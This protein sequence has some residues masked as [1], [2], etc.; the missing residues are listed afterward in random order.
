MAPGLKSVRRRRY[1]ALSCIGWA[2]LERLMARHYQR[3]GYAVEHVGTGGT[4]QRFDGGIDLKLRKGSAYVLVQCK[5]WNAKQVPHNAVHELLGLMVNERATGAVLVTSGEFTRAAIEAA[6]KQDRVQLVDGDA[7]RTLLGPLLDDEP[8]DAVPEA[9]TPLGRRPS[10]MATANDTWAL[11]LLLLF[12][13]I[14]FAL[15]LLWAMSSAFRQAL[16]PIL[17]PRPPVSG[18]APVVRPEPSPIA[19]APTTA[20]PPVDA[21]VEA[22]VAMP[23]P[24]PDEIRA[25]RRKADEA[26]RVIEATTPA[27]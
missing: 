23:A 13:K 17:V 1:D 9:R 19:S 5:H 22:P 7:L 15:A 4:R 3:E 8:A 24:T 25:S 18:V 21:P 26:M 16:S 6:G 2:Q 14:G 12:L 27:M 20:L 10:R 11:G